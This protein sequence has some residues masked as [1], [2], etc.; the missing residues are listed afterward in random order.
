MKATE[1]VRSQGSAK[2]FTLYL[3]IG[4]AALTFGTYR[5]SSSFVTKPTAPY[6]ETKPRYAY[7]D[8]NEQAAWVNVTLR[9]NASAPQSNFPINVTITVRGLFIPQGNWSYAFLPGATAAFPEKEPPDWNHNPKNVIVLKPQKSTFL[10][11]L[12]GSRIINYTSGGDWNI[13]LHVVADTVF[14]I[15]NIP[16]NPT[17]L[18]MQIYTIPNAVH[19]ASAESIAQINALEESERNNGLWS[20]IALIIPGIPLLAQAI[21]LYPRKFF[22][23]KCKD[24]GFPNR[25]PF[26]KTFYV[27][28]SLIKCKKCGML[29]VKERKPRYNK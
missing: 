15:N 11:C 23:I 9:T 18:P 14:I 19:I 24:C 1:R 25:I 6:S 3:I 17:N 22:E 10:D 27:E 16:P 21:R 26:S 8:K 2:F 20:G 12:V 5:L 28:E 13:D 7:N 4:L 29:L